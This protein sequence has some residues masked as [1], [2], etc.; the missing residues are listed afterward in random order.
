MLASPLTIISRQDDSVAI[1]A[2]VDIIHQQGA[3]K[4]VIGLPYSMDGTLGM[5]AEKVQAFVDGLCCHTDVPVVFRD[6]RLTTV[7]ARRLMK[8]AKVRGKADDAPAAAVILQGYLDEFI[9]R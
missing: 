9:G 5:Q 6:E 2:I 1:A 4:V 7:L 3:E 8:E